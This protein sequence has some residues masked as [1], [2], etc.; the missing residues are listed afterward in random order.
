MPVPYNKIIRSAVPAVERERRGEDGHP[1]Y[2]IR[3]HKPGLNR[4]A[5]EVPGKR[6]EM[7]TVSNVLEY[8]QIQ[9]RGSTVRTEVIAGATTFAT[10]AYILIIQP[11]YMGEAGMDAVGVLLAT[12]LV[13]GLVTIVMGLV[14][15]MPF[16][17][18]PGMGSNAVLANSIVLAG[19][20]SW[21]VGLGMV[22]ISGTVFLLLSI[23]GVRELIVKLIPKD[24]KIN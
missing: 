10:M 16:A 21:Q 11:K 24:I 14:S 22:F 4:T 15:N 17:L 20:A 19:I 3:R 8:F 18:A 12:A 5:R 23:F 6:K 1:V 7:Q 9:K 2:R 13:S